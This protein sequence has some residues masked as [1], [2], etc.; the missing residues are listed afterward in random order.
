MEKW[1]DVIGFEGFYQ[2]SNFGRVKSLARIR[3]NP[4]NAPC[5]SKER[6]MTI[7]NNSNGYPS[8]KLRKHGISKTITVHRLVSLHFIENASALPDI[9]HKNGI[10]TD[11]RSENLEWV[12][13]S[14]NNFHAISS[15]LRTYKKSTL[16]I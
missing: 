6:I 13:Q 7:H 10:K 5:M 16:T 3:K 2:I 11:N 12:T 1:K 4:F 14:E 8:L 9:N 15:G